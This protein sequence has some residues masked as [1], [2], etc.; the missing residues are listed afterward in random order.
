MSKFF[1]TK[2][3]GIILIIL[4]ALFFALMNMFVRMS[5]D[6]PTMQKVF[7]RNAV[8]LIYSL[9]LLLRDPKQFKT[10]KGNVPT[11]I[12]RAVCGTLG[13][14]CN[15]YAVDNMAIADASMLNKLSP[16]FALVFSFF[17]L[18][19]KPT[20]VDWIAVAAAFGGA[21]FVIKPGFSLEAV[22]ALVGTAGGLAAGLA[23]TFVRKASN[24]GA[25]RNL[26][27]F[28]F[29]AFSCLVAAPFMI[30]DFHPMTWQQVM[31][32][33]LAGTS[34]TLGQ[35]FITAA[36]AKAPAKE[37]SVF[38]YTIVIFTA[39]LGMIF[40]SEVPDV[41]S[42][43]GYAVIIGVA[44]GK[45]LLAMHADKK[46]AERAKAVEAAAEKENQENIDYKEDG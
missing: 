8:A 33:L 18:K 23:Y 3:Q 21:L 28:V 6:L 27:I 30:F 17:L 37:I 11:L 4:S 43:I 7:F 38:D 19:E 34:A 20:K 26:I 41:F 12:F 5:G 25:S 1:K 24:G 45:W 44:V 35:V 42:F 29:S 36:Y 9:A 14:I 2:Y 31:F 16:F 40:L 13:V 46:E 10:A 22:P 32:L 39:V 15:F